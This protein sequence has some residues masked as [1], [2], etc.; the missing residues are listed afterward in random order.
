[1]KNIIMKTLAGLIFSAS[2]LFEMSCHSANDICDQN[3][4]SNAHHVIKFSEATD[5]IW[6]FQATFGGSTEVTENGWSEIRRAPELDFFETPGVGSTGDSLNHCGLMLYFCFD[7]INGK[8]YLAYNVSPDL[9][10]TAIPF[11]IVGLTGNLSTSVCPGHFTSSERASLP[12]I[13][14]AIKTLRFVCSTPAGSQTIAVI[15]DDGE[16][17]MRHINRM[18]SLPS[19]AYPVAFFHRTQV[20]ELIIQNDASSVTSDKCSGIRI[21]MGYADSPGIGKIIKAV[22]F[23]I[24]GNGKNIIRKFDGSNA[25]MLQKSWPP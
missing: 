7:S 5:H 18:V 11:P 1:M 24:D 4:V 12:D 17:F 23:A 3:I 15:N 19:G 25:R 14:N 20:N 6:D 2:L 10:P 8:Y 22:A 16:K 13:S 9:S 21:Y